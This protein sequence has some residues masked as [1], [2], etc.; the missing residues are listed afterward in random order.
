MQTALSTFVA[1]N[2]QAAVTKV[3]DDFCVPTGFLNTSYGRLSFEKVA[4]KGTC[5]MGLLDFWQL[6]IHN[7]PR[8]NLAGNSSILVSPAPLFYFP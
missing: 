5:R 2:A 7:S 1:F 8:P 6:M 4:D 3:G